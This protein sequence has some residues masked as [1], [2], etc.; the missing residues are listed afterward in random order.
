[1]NLTVKT[2]PR[3][4]GYLK[5]DLP[6][7]NEWS[8]HLLSQLK[9]ALSVVSS[10]DISSVKGDKIDI[11]ENAIKG[12]SVEIT[13]DSVSVSIDGNVVFSVSPDGLFI[14][15]SDESEYIRLKNDTINIKVAEIECDVLTASEADI[16]V[17]NG[18]ETA[19]S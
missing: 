18:T 6:R 2:P 3:P 16:A 7:L 1:M 8:N 11:S 13:D 19:T 4:S 10:D 5:R 15:N 14:R 12:T 9:A 17:L